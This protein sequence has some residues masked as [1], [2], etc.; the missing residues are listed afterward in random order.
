MIIK[1]YRV[2]MVILPERK[3]V[4]RYYGYIYTNYILKDEDFSPI[5][6]NFESI[7]WKEIMFDLI[8]KSKN[9]FKMAITFYI[10][11]HGLFIKY[12]VIFKSTK[13]HQTCHLKLMDRR[14][15]F[16]IL[17]PIIYSV[18]LTIYEKVIYYNWCNSL[19]LPYFRIIYSYI[20]LKSF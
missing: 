15:E 17:L 10:F 12:T 3:L 4:R 9:Q 6:M 13:I 19:N 1:K 5:W 8:Y 16:S 18:T 2:S 11:Y 14:K 20:S 7:Y